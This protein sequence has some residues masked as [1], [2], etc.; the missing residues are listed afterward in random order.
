MY[1]DQVGEGDEFNELVLPRG[2]EYRLVLSDGTSVR[3]NSGS[4]LRYPVSF[5]G[6]ERTVELSGEAFFE[7]A[8][9]SLRPFSVKTDGL[10]VKAYGTSFNINTLKP[11]HV[12][13][14]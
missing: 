6:K 9:D 2:G 7:V 13:S 10:V 5:S 14:A 3:L 11:G 4:I 12:Y 8:T 1:T